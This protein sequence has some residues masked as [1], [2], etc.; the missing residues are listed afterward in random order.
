VKIITLTPEEVEALGY[1]LDLAYDD[2]S[3]YLDTGNPEVDYGAEWPE[4]ARIKARQ[5]SALARLG[6]CAGLHGEL[7][8]WSNL[9]KAVLS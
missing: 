9:A 5:Y 8:R 7:E 4:V 3:A 2:Q 1:A 6:D